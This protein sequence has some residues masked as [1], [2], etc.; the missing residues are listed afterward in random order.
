MSNLPPEIVHLI[1]QNVREDALTLKQ[2]ALVNQ[3]WLHEAQ[4][5]LFKLEIEYT[6]ADEA[7]LHSSRWRTD[8]LI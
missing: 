5:L 8:L 6:P 2:C 7:L 1:L 3:A 4:P